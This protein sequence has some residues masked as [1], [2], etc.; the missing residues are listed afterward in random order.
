MVLIGG[1]GGIVVG[2]DTL[3]S[4]SDIS[5]I[6]AARRDCGSINELAG[7]GGPF[8]GTMRTPN[9]FVAVSSPPWGCRDSD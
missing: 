9:T 4:S 7:D 5:M 8:R 6:L 3:S 1:E 2:T